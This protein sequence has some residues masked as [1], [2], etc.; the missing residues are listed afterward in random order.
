MRKVKQIKRGGRPVRGGV[1]PRVEERNKGSGRQRATPEGE[2]GEGRTG[3]AGG[4]T[5]KARQG[6]KSATITAAGKARTA[7]APDGKSRRVTTPVVPRGERSGSKGTRGGTTPSQRTIRVRELVPQQVCGPRT[8]VHRVFRVEERLSN[9][10]QTH[11]VFNDHH[12]WYCEHGTD[13]HAVGEVRK[14]R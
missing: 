13:C 7:A 8:R 3:Q 11:L 14:A 12:G 2:T 1:A 4:K 10:S 5:F 6:G 9:S